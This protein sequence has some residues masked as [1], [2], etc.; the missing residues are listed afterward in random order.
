MDRV[1]TRPKKKAP[2]F[3][4][5]AEKADF[6]RRGREKVRQGNLGLGPASVQP[7]PLQDLDVLLRA[8]EVARD[9]SRR[10]VH[11]LAG[12]RL[13]IEL[14]DATELLEPARLRLLDE[15]MRVELDGH[16]RQATRPNPLFP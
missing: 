6:G 4:P 12:A 13:T 15:K 1:G 2:G 3:E 10:L 11:A 7:G 8:A 16:G 14:D 5:G 9:D